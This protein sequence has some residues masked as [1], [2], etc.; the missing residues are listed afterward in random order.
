MMGRQSA[1]DELFYRFRLEDRIPEDHPL[2]L[3]DALLNFDKARTVLAGHYSHTGRPSVDPGLM[4][5]MLLIGYAYGI[6]SERRLCREVDL[7]GYTAYGRGDVRRYR[8]RDLVQARAAVMGAHAGRVNNVVAGTVL[9]CG[10]HG[11]HWRSAFRAGEQAG[12]LT[13]PR[14]HE[15]LI[16]EV[17]QIA[18]RQLIAND[19][20]D[21]S[22]LTLDEQGQ[23][24]KLNIDPQYFQNHAMKERLAG[25]LRRDFERKG[26]VRYAVV[27]ECWLARSKRKMADETLEDYATRALDE[28]A[29]QEFSP[30]RGDGRDEV[31]LIYVSDRRGAGFI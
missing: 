18:K 15:Q 6:R 16:D 13:A 26:I 5:R 7:I 29:R 8:R 17:F 25:E 12:G 9:G 31:I 30:S 20:L 3:L 27:A 23:R 28:Y 4:L 19:R 14:D 24:A 2:R 1:P 11:K 10:T 21:F 22:V